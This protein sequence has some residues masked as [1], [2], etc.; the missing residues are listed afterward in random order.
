[1][2]AVEARPE[3]AGPES[4]RKAGWIA[5][6]T[7]SQLIPERGVAVLVAGHQVALFRVT[8]AIGEDFVYAVGHRD[9]F[10]DANVI[11]RGIVGSVGAGDDQRDTVAS[12][13]YKHVFVLATGECLTDPSERLPVYRTW[14]AGGVVYVN[15][16][17]VGPPALT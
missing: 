17:P 14:V 16:V 8:S 1:M 10:A 4:P 9:P 7:M 11:A 5:V 3:V 2:T 6:C 12:P 15:P 13:M